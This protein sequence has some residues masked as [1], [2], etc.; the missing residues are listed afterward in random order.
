MWNDIRG[1]VKLK[2][3]KKSEKNSDWPDTNDP[4]PYPLKKKL[5]TCITTKN[6][7]KTQKK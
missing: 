3:I 5:E 7:T 2:K 1:L 4:P 6:N